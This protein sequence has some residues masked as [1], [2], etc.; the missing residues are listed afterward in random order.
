MKP[1][2]LRG[3]AG[4]GLFAFALWL[5]DPARVAGAL[6]Q[7]DPGWLAA[8]VIAS[9]CAVFFAA[10]RWRSLARWLGMEVPL[11]LAM[12]AQWRGMAANSVLPGAIIGGDAL[13]ALH[14]QRAGHGF[15]AAAASVAL[16]RVSGLWVLVIISLGISAIA[17][18]AGLLP[19]QALPLAWP[20]VCL[21]TAVALALPVLLWSLSDA[22]RHRL[23]GKLAQLLDAIHE[24]PRPLREY[25]RQL[26]YS[27]AV[28]TCFIVA[29]ACGA[30]A[31]GLVLPW[32]LYFIAAGPI[33]I[34][35]ALPL[36]VGGWGTR[37]AAAAVTLA[38]FGAPREQAVASAVLYGLFAVIQGLLGSL[39]LLSSKRNQ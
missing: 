21:M 4:L 16:D 15:G 13:R 6:G 31:V 30:R 23:P 7:L 10:L 38:L 39:T 11:R 32:W 20:V 17:L 33:F 14:L 3:L 26:L 29:F 34:L 5:A 22:T 36:S 28:Q 25:G 37:E 9:T 18:A 12:L 19:A 27:G 1:A 8:G 24:R 35:A 2:I